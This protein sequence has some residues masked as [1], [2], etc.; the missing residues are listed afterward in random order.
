MDKRSHETIHKYIYKDQWKNEILPLKNQFHHKPLFT[1]LS[2]M[3]AIKINLNS[4]WIIQAFITY[5]VN[6]PI[7][8]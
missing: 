4:I 5:I 3:H 6:K 2:T 7:N 8:I 1:R